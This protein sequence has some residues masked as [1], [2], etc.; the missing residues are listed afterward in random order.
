MSYGH[1]I[2]VVACAAA[3]LMAIATAAAQDKAKYPVVRG[4]W[5]AVGG[6]V[7]YVPDKPRGLGQ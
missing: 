2:G 6:S 5:T 7:K 1:S 4:Q 3:L